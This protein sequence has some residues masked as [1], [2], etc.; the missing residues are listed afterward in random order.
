MRNRE[1]KQQAK[2]DAMFTPVPEDEGRPIY[3]AAQQ[4]KL[5]GRRIFTCTVVVGFTSGSGLGIGGKKTTR[6]D[7]WDPS[8]LLEAVEDL[9]W[10]L[11]TL[12]HLWVQTEHNASI[13]NAA[14]IRGVIQAHMLFRRA[15]P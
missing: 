8:T 10:E 2:A 9:G 12:D 13:G 6:Y 3:E 5:A 4:A 1:D 11:V 14:N 15:A 7:R